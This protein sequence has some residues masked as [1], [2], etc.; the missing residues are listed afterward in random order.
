M[1]GW[2]FGPAQELRRAF[3]LDDTKLGPIHW[4]CPSKSAAVVMSVDDIF[5]GTSQSAYEAVGDLEGGCIRTLVVAT[6]AT[7]TTAVNPFRHA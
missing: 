2:Q 5:P 6:R 3:I 7:S 1:E 4:Y